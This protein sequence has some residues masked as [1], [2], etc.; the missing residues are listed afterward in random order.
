MQMN[1]PNYLQKMAVFLLNFNHFNNR[2]YMDLKRKEFWKTFLRV[3]LVSLI[4]GVMGTLIGS[5]W[6]SGFTILMLIILLIYSIVKACRVFKIRAAIRDEL[7]TKET[8]YACATWRVI[9]IMIP[10]VIVMVWL[11]FVWIIFAALENGY[12]G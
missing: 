8:A 3:F 4:L 1:L 11:G 5:A 7:D 10:P 2:N 6:G 12:H 9:A